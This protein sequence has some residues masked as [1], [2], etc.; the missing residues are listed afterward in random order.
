MEVRDNTVVSP[1][2]TEFVSHLNPSLISGF[3]NLS[4]F[5][6]QTYS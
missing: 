3:E 4:R 5:S 6:A 2:R 1:R